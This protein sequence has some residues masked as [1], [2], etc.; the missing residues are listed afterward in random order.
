VRIAAATAFGILWF[1]SACAPE[2]PV[3]MGAA[4]SQ[5]RKIEACTTTDVAVCRN[6]TWQLKTKCSS[7]CQ[8]K[9]IGHGSTVPLCGE[10]WTKKN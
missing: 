2:E 9:A 6:G 1:V 5:T 4:C 10:A 8:R 7:P 3:T